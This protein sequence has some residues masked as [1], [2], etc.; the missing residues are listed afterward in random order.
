MFSQEPYGHLVSSDTPAE[1]LYTE[2]YNLSAFL[3]YKLESQSQFS[4]LDASFLKRSLEMLNLLESRA[5]EHLKISEVKKEGENLELQDAKINYFFSKREYKQITDI[6]GADVSSNYSPSTHFKIG[7][8]Y[9]AQKQ[10]SEAKLFFSR[11]NGNSQYSDAS[12]YY[13]GMCSYFLSDYAEAIALLKS[14]DN[15]E[16][17]NEY[18]PL[19]ITKLLYSQEKYTEAISYGES[20]LK[21]PSTQQKQEIEYLI[22]QSYFVLKDNNKALAYLSKYEKST[23]KLS[24][25]DFYQ[26]GLLNYQVGNVDI[27][28][29]H[30]AELIFCDSPICYSGQHLL[31]NLYAKESKTQ[32]AAALYSKLSKSATDQNLKDLFLYNAAI[33]FHKQG[34]YS[35]SLHKANQVFKSS[36]TY[37]ASQ[38]L[39]QDIL[40]HSEDT[41]G[42]ITFLEQQTQLS[43]K[44]QNTLLTLHLRLLQQFESENKLSEAM[45]S[46]HFIKESN[47]PKTIQIANYYQGRILFEQSKFAEAFESLQSAKSSSAFQNNYLKYMQGYTASKLENHLDAVGYLEQVN[48]S[49]PQA[50][51]PFAIH[52]EKVKAFNYLKVSQF[53]KAQ[54][55]FEIAAKLGDS[56]SIYKLSELA[57]NEGD[58]YT[59]IYLLESYI[60]KTKSKEAIQ[61]A[62]FTIGERLI[63]LKEITR[64]MPYFT[65]AYAAFQPPNTLSYAAQLSK[66]LAWYRLGQ[67]EEAI[68]A[69]KEVATDSKEGNQQRIA[70]RALEDI[71]LNKIK[72]TKAFFDFTDNETEIVLNAIEKDSLAY[73]LANNFYQENNYIEAIP[74]Y[75][76]YLQAYQNGIYTEQAYLELGESEFAVENYEGSLNAYSKI[77]RSENTG[78]RERA[79]LRSALINLNKLNRQADALDNFWSLLN[80]PDLTL[81]RNEIVSGA[82]Y[83]ATAIQDPKIPELADIIIANPADDKT[84]ANAHYHKGKFEFKQG[85][86]DDA[87]K[88]FT[89]VTRLSKQAISAESNYQ[90]ASIFYQKGNLDAAERQAT[91]TTKRAKNYP[92]WVAKSLL[93]LSDIYIDK[94]DL[95]NAR[96]ATE[97]V[98][99]NYQKDEEILKEAN[100]KL[101]LITTLESRN[102][103]VIDIETDT[104]FFE[105]IKD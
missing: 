92:F 105:D 2:N 66:G 53:E 65:N 45:S 5:I 39:I 31:A 101:D 62:N 81:D 100:D 83:C 88:H 23:S 55:A 89:E 87:I 86:D 59:E 60:D 14:I 94:E 26:L 63:E 13:S 79:L 64:A 3:T 43:P 77:T 16:P 52:L 90:I 95:L 19:Y 8:A 78:Y 42:G 22:G 47:D 67:Y 97:V 4:K 84:L 9:F 98:I 48:T 38:A 44:L 70:V 85:R 104:L 29:Q 75:A 28:K 82:F 36:E 41:Y 57:R 17:Y 93:L 25:D 80:L 71:Y 46:L 35:Q 72:D 91:E 54:K 68:A 15:K 6:V 49:Q 20:K 21:Q 50:D 102:S 24:A 56:Y 27:A 34:D 74:A 33:L 58:H 76:R 18:N 37:T 30:L 69:Y 61:Q 1:I 96:A 51:T 103:R 11:L 32:E 10:F 73:T 7:Y 99:E 12:T 40:L